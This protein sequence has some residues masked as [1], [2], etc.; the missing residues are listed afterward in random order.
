MSEQA[1]PTPPVGSIDT[2]ELAMAG[3]KKLKEWLERI[4][5]SHRKWAIDCLSADNSTT[6]D[7]ADS[8]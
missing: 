7:K 8:E 6:D 3:L 4:P 1:Q 5:E 2:L